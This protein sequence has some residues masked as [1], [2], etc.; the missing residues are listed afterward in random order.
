MVGGRLRLKHVPAL[1]FVY[2]ASIAGQDRIEQLLQELRDA[3]PP[4]S[5][6]DER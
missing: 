1:S 2:D 4:P 5:D 6:D 3:A